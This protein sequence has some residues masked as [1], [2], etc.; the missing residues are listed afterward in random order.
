MVGSHRVA[1]PGVQRSLRTSD[2]VVV[3][4]GPLG[5]GRSTALRR[6]GEDLHAEG[7]SLTW[8]ATL[9]LPDDVTGYVAIE[10]V[11]GR[12]TQ[13]WDEVV[14]LV[15]T[16]GDVRLR[17]T[18]LTPAC[19]PP[20]LGA[21]IVDNLR[22]SVEQVAEHVRATDS[23]AD[24][25]LLRA[26]AH[27]H[28]G[29]IAHL[30]AC[31]AQTLDEFRALLARKRPLMPLP[32]A[33]AA[34]AVPAFLSPGV[35]AVLGLPL[36]RLDALESAGQGEWLSHGTAAAFVLLPQVREATRAAMD[37]LSLRLH[38]AQRRD[39]AEAL[40]TEGATYA[41]F[42]EAVEAGALDVASR[43]ARTSDLFG[44]PAHAIEIDTVLRMVPAKELARHP[45]LAF[46]LA[47][48][49]SATSASP[50]RAL[51]YFETA[52]EGARRAAPTSDADRVY[53]YAI[54]SAAERIAG[55]RDCGLGAARRATQALALLNPGELERLGE[56]ASQTC[57][58][59]ALTLLTHGRL[60]EAA[61]AF[62]AALDVAR[63]RS[64]EM[65]SLVGLARVETDRGD[66]TRAAHWV[67]MAEEHANR[68]KATRRSQA[69]L[70]VV[71]AHAAIESGEVAR[72]RASVERVWPQADRAEHWEWLGCT[73]AL[74]LLGDG[75]AVLALEEL[76]ALRQ[77]RSGRTVM[78]AWSTAR[79]D[80]TEVLLLV[81]TGNLRAARAVAKAA[82]PGNL[83]RTSEAIVGLASDDLS[84]VRDAVGRMRPVTPAERVWAS[85]LTAVLLRRE[86]RNDEWRHTMEEVQVLHE[87]YGIS[88]P[89]MFL[90]AEERAAVGGSAAVLPCLLPA[91]SAVPDLT[92]RELV[93]LQQLVHT[94]DVGEIA[95][96]LHV[97][98]NTVK[99][100]R[101]SLYRK[102][103]ATSR[104]ETLAVGLAHGLLKI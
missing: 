35:L 82:P 79:L 43:A 37:P 50:R 77:R 71:A 83:R 51:G 92:P 57:A 30:C 95:Q 6:L 98:P 39:C 84:L 7:E 9:P 73:R 87:T 63:H 28:V 93:V 55:L 42:I 69:L 70:R 45:V 4:S 101:R 90:P 80:H 97:S 40:L 74:T 41:A 54:Q 13:F 32:V 94:A 14:H 103:G 27:G 3:L 34:L 102:L 53:L 104:D 47:R 61:T 85:A 88:S 67:R 52:A 46:S 19:L 38:E 18:S 12:D 78:P 64:D 10:D 59:I 48:A 89:F 68:G 17:L 62:A 2:P 65:V 81:A 1:R 91:S 99:S 49:A 5:S 33:D 8:A 100:Q 20:G 23:P 75:Q 72:A 16:R 56:T 31:G 66:L 15:R 36:E 24:P 86:G 44:D 11:D 96:S 22:L 21:V 29:T 60:D 58:H 76:R 26:Y 25:H